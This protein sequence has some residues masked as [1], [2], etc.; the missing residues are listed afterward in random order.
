MISSLSVQ[1]SY[2]MSQNA[3]QR[4]GMIEITQTFQKTCM[5]TSS[6]RKSLNLYIP[7]GV[8]GL[9]AQFWRYTRLP[10]TC[11]DCPP[12]ALAGQSSNVERPCKMPR[13]VLRPFSAPEVVA[14][15]ASCKPKTP[16]PEF[17]ELLTDS[18]ASGSSSAA[19]VFSV[20][21]KRYVFLCFPPA[22][23]LFNIDITT[24]SLLHCCNLGSTNCCFGYAMAGFAWWSCQRFWRYCCSAFKA[25][26][27]WQVVC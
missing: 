27:Q 22:A 14:A 18:F 7:A 13:P 4:P 23:S 12:E 21:L 26:L 15:R 11:L 6:L 25:W 20:M 9:F 10:A 19:Q 17:G 16:A 24:D 8:T 2:V 5:W 1:D 3:K